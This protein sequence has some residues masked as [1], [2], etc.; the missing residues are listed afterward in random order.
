MVAERVARGIVGIGNSVELVWHGGEPL[1]C[2]LK[3]FSQLVFPF[4]QL[5]EQGLVR[6]GIQTNATFINEDWCE[7]FRSH[8]FQVGVSIDGPPWANQRRVGWDGKPAF[9]RIMRGIERLR[10]TDIPFNVI[11]VVSGDTL[12]RGK[13]LYNFFIELGC[14]SFGVNIEEQLCAHIVTISS[15]D[16]GTTVT[17]FWQEL[18]AAW[19]ENPV[20]KV[21]EFTRM[22]PS[23]A[24]FNDGQSDFPKLY[25]IFPSVAWNG[26]VVL[27]APEFLNTNALRYGNF[28]VGN[29]LE[30]DLQVIVERGKTTSYVQDFVHGVSRC[31]DECEHFLLCCGGQAGNKF[32][33]C[34]TT[35]AT[36]TAFCRNSEKRLADAILKDLERSF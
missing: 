4:E 31:K 16:H 9:D 26:D 6:Y 18:F 33:E 10:E 36:E 27:L 35:D 3:H 15:D 19:Q 23:L 14:D 28:V 7:F 20:M 29:V 1:S 17:R 24:A 32:F 21:R 22:L 2:G 13:E 12:N 25:D 8:R 5:R 11:C 34:D 30:E